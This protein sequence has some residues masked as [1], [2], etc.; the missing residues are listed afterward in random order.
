MTCTT[1]ELEGQKFIVCQRGRRG[2][3]CWVRHCDNE[4]DYLC[5]GKRRDRGGKSCDRPLCAE[6]TRRVEEQNIDH[7]PP[8]AKQNGVQLSLLPQQGGTRR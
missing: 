6:H 3:K 7:C 8:C 1:I 4:A 2:R 5:D